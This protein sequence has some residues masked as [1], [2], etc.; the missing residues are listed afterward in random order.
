MSEGML[1]GISVVALTI[2]AI[3]GSSGS[4]TA[5]TSLDQYCGAVEQ[6]RQVFS[7][8]FG[9]LSRETNPY[10]QQSIRT[11]YQPQTDA[12]RQNL[13][14]LL[15][16]EFQGFRGTITKLFF[17]QISGL[18]IELTMTAPC[19]SFTLTITMA[20]NQGNWNSAPMGARFEQFP[21]LKTLHVGDSVTA[22]GR[23]YVIRN[24]GGPW[25]EPTLGDG[26]H[27]PIIGIRPVSLVR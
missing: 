9:E 26:S 10:M 12:V 16:S 20:F 6:G 11:K 21:I 25:I 4:A 22:S 17:T 5:Q 19:R 13:K 27:N 14:T 18:P 24:L 7:E 15:S 3:I 1:K 2:G 8:M 23:P